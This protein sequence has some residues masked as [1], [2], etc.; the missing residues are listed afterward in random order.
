MVLTDSSL[1]WPPPDPDRMPRLG[2][3]PS[4]EQPFVYGAD[5]STHQNNVDAFRRRQREDLK[6]YDAG[7]TTSIRRRPFRERYEKTDD[8]DEPLTSKSG[9]FDDSGSG[10]EGWRDSE[11]DRLDDFGVDE[12][13]EFYDEDDV[14][15]AELLRRRNKTTQ[16]NDGS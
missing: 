9:Q 6:R 13:A 10:E 5:M 11:G 12:D 7:A 3:Q 15:L 4:F 16:H 1:S 14:P 2:N 8:R